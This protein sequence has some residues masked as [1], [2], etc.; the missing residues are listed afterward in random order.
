MAVECDLEILV[1][2]LLERE[3]TA[4]PTMQ[5]VEQWRR[6]ADLPADPSTVLGALLSRFDGLSVEHD[7]VRA[8]IRWFGSTVVAGEKS[9]FVLMELWA[10]GAHAAVLGLDRG[11]DRVFGVPVSQDATARIEHVLRDTI[12]QLRAHGPLREAHFLGF[13]ADFLQ[14]LPRRLVASA[15]A[16]S[17]GSWVLEHGIPELLGEACELPLARGQRLTVH[18]RKDESTFQPAKDGV[19]FAPVVEA[20]RTGAKGKLLGET[21]QQVS[22][23]FLGS[24]TMY[25]PLPDAAHRGAA[26]EVLRRWKMELARRVARLPSAEVR[27][28]MPMDLPWPTSPLALAVQ[29]LRHGPPGPRTSA[30]ELGPLA[31]ETARML[32]ELDDVEVAQLD[33]PDVLRAYQ[34]GAYTLLLRRC[35]DD[36][37]RVEESLWVRRGAGEILPVVFWI[38]EDRAAFSADGDEPAYRLF[39]QWMRAAIGAGGHDRELPNG[40][41]PS[42]WFLLQ[43]RDGEPLDH[44]VVE[45]MVSARRYAELE[46]IP[47]TAEA[48]DGAN[49]AAEMFRALVRELIDPNARFGQR[50]AALGLP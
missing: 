4:S 7:G 3:L 40:I 6:R 27:S 24:D 49:E 5:E 9:L 50:V 28:L 45:G 44:R 2:P 43:D 36:D 15:P 32:R 13:V 23:G 46:D 41:L 20:R 18:V 33:V 21:E 19:W 30:G 26:L 16:E 11:H 35:E 34:V 42:E 22:M 17:L 37:E 48:A 14:G 8:T 38:E 39:A 1:T 12:E 47:S 31:R 29:A 10:E 25:E